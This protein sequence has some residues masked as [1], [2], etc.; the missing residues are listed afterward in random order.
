MNGT[1]IFPALGISSRIMATGRDWYEMTYR[2]MPRATRG[3]ELAS[4]IQRGSCGSIRTRKLPNPN[5]L[6]DPQ[7]IGS[8]TSP[9]QSERKLKLSLCKDR[10][11]DLYLNGK[12]RLGKGKEINLMYA[13]STY[14]NPFLL[15]SF[16]LLFSTRWRKHVGRM[17]AD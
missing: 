4:V 8:R 17:A 16:S 1:R 15:V 9:V 10:S 14:T 6:F 7:S 3:K 2:Q 12:Q 11:E 5:F 13:S